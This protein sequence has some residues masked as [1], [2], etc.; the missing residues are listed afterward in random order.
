MPYLLRRVILEDRWETQLAELLA[1]CPRA[2]ISEVL[3]MEQSHQLLMAPYPLDKHRR[4]AAIYRQMAEQLRAA[5]IVFS[6]I[7]GIKANDGM[8]Y[9]Y[10]FSLKLV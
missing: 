3:L 10:P 2:G 5:G 8:E 9:S 7:A 6:I 1:F 4:L